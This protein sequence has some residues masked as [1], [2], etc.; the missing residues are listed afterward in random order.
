M[1]ASGLPNLSAASLSSQAL[2]AL[3]GAIVAGA[4][5]DGCLP[6]EHDLTQQFGVSRTTARSA[7]KTLEQVGII[8]RKLGRGT[9]IRKYARPDVLILHGLVAFSRCYANEGTRSRL[10]RR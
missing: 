3:V 6:Y 5:D 2:N 9:R 8:E 10:E 7:L 1:K 4:F